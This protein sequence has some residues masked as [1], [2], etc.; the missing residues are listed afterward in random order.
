MLVEMDKE[1][2]IEIVR[3]PTVATELE[4]VTRLLV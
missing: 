2:E 1:L 4:V 3:V